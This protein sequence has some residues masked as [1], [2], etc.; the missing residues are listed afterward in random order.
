MNER[1]PHIEPLGTHH[2]RAAFSCGVSALERYLRTQARQDMTRRVAAVFVLVGDSPG[3][4]AG[5][6]TLA[7][8]GVLLGEL[9]ADVARRLPR[10][11]LVPA[12]LL[13]RLAVD[14]RY[15]GCGYGEFLLMDAMQRSWHHSADIAS[16]AL[17]VDAK[18]GAAGRFYERYGF[19]AFP[20]MR[21]RLFLPMATIERMFG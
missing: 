3:V 12:T 4:I 15:R 10:Y 1:R 17:I 8:T 13:G 7:A 19:V 9:P 18:D 21:G 2:D 20:T 16:V 5:Y 6:Y 14:D 11:P